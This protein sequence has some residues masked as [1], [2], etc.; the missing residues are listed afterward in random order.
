[1][2][3]S[4]KSFFLASFIFLL[5]GLTN[6][7]SAS[8]GVWGFTAISWSISR[9]DNT[10][11]TTDIRD[12]HFWCEGRDRSSAF[13][14]E[15]YEKEIKSFDTLVYDCTYDRGLA[16]GTCTRSYELLNENEGIFTVNAQVI[17]EIDGPAEYTWT[18]NIK[19]VTPSQTFIPTAEVEE[20]T[21][22]VIA[23]TPISIGFASGT[24]PDTSVFLTQENSSATIKRDDGTIIEIKPQTLAVFNP[25]V[26][27]TGTTTLIHGEVSTTVDCA[28]STRDFSVKTAIANV[29]GSC[30][31]TKNLSDTADFTTNYSQEGVNGEL[32]VTVISGTVDITDRQSNTF[33]LTA[34]QEKTIQSA[35]PRTSWV[36]PI[37]GDKIYGGHSNLFVWTAYPDAS[38]YI[39]EYNLSTPM[40]THENASS[41]EY[42]KQVLFLTS[43]DYT[44]Y[45]DLIIYPL[46]LPNGY[47]G[48]VVEIRIFAIDA[49]GNP[50]RE[51]VSSDRA[52]VTWKDDVDTPSGATSFR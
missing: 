50:I 12:G 44:R 4:K 30:A 29:A 20:V 52:T 27:N 21:G 15:P 35:V 34:E 48:V 3:N 23:V 46:D 13:A 8:E 38:S 39:L 31:S 43:A 18:Y 51:S 41:I 5:F 25:T 36:L 49:T 10:C 16:H 26:E 42:T 24:I 19:K 14:K 17:Y 9:S 32:T 6:V 11:E 2:I 33:T 47:E 1:M 22:E 37:D 40:F 45:E 28:S 7:V